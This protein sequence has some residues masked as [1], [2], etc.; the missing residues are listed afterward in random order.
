MLTGSRG[1]CRS[2]QRTELPFCYFPL[3]G[4]EGSVAAKMVGEASYSNVNWKV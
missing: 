4:S 2:Y 3:I 1:E